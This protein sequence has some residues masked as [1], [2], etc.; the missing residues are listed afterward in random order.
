[1]LMSSLGYVPNRPQNP[2]VV[3]LLRLCF[4]IIPAAFSLL[5]LPVLVRGPTTRTITG[6]NGPNHLGLWYNALPEHQM[7]LISSSVSPAPA[8]A[9]ASAPALVP[10]AA[11][12]AAATAESRVCFRQGAERSGHS[13]VPAG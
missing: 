5:G 11:A 12:T 4:S 10:A 6:H 8:S 7:A 1:M 13:A 2:E 9:P 3:W